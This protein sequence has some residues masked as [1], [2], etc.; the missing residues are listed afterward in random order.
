[1]SIL[2][3][4]GGRVNVAVVAALAAP[5]V[6]HVGVAICR[7]RFIDLAARLHVHWHGESGAAARAGRAVA[8]GSAALGSFSAIL[9][10][11]SAV[12]SA[13]IVV[14]FPRFRSAAFLRLRA[15][16]ARANI[17]FV[18]SATRLLQARVRVVVDGRGTQ[19]D[20]ARRRCGCCVLLGCRARGRR[21]CRRSS[22]FLVDYSPSCSHGVGDYDS[23]GA[24]G[25]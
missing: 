22:C 13:I 17:S 7:A 24:A 6:Y 8:A 18:L 19:G 5:R 10:P 12:Q 14:V 20:R 1:M 4:H 15:H 11:L 9:T 25:R 3:G 23:G 16:L 21:C 2:D